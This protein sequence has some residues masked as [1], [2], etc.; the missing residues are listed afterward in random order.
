MNQDNRLL[1][2]GLLMLMA[3][4]LGRWNPTDPLLDQIGHER[5]MAEKIRREPFFEASHP[6]IC[7]EQKEF[8]K[9]APR[10]LRL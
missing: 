2:K 6:N 9:Q 7:R 5:E 8:N 1:Q 4:I 3:D 10:R